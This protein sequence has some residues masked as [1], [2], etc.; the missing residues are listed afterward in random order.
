[1]DHDLGQFGLGLVQVQV[2]EFV[3][4]EVPERAVAPGRVVEVLDPLGHGDRQLEVGPPLLAVQQPL[5]LGI[6]VS[7]GVRLGDNRESGR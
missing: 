2:F 3:R 6:S 7:S 1:M 4:S 5:E